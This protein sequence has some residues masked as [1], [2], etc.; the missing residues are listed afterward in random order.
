[1]SYTNPIDIIED[2]A[3]TKGYIVKWEHGEA[4][5]LW[6]SQAI[7]FCRDT[8]HKGLLSIYRRDVMLNT[9]M[10]GKLKRRK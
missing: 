7:A 8:A 4:Y 1:M 5:F 3:F 6:E 10:N 2:K 9:Y